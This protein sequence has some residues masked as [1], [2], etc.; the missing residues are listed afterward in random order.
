MLVGPLL[1]SWEQRQRRR[2]EPMVM[3]PLRFPQLLELGKERGSWVV[4]R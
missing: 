4:V 1:T 2:R 3:A